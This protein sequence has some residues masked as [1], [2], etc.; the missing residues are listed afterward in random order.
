MTTWQ[1]G[2]ELVTQ[3]RDLA[4][5]PLREFVAQLAS[6]RPP[7]VRMVGKAVFLNRGK[8]LAP[9]A[10]RANVEHN[11]VLHE[12]VII[13]SIET[14]PVPR[15]PDEERIEIDALDYSEDGVVHVTANF[16]YM[17]RPNIPEVPRL[18]DPEQTEGPINIDDA[19]YF[20]SR[21]E[22]RTGSAPTMPAWRKH[23]FVA[24]SHI[25]ADAAEYFGLPADRTVVMGARIQV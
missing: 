16:G 21:L 13:M 6:Y 15:V 23:L 24:T 17:E 7:L 18:L 11:R 1:R 19:S 9:L 22:L 4:E 20:L 8:A 5:G 10:L 12:H 2:S 14:L 3:A 25:A